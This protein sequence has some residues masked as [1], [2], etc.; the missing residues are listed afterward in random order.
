VPKAHGFAN[1]EA[2]G[3][4]NGRAFANPERKNE[5]FGATLMQE[6]RLRAYPKRMEAMGL[7][8]LGQ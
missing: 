3:T 8:D 5:D 2:S 4:P 6:K 1:P 7:W